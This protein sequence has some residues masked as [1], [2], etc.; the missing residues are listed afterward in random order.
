VEVKYSVAIKYLKGNR[1]QVALRHA[2]NAISNLKDAHLSS[3]FFKR[4]AYRKEDNHS[5]A[6][7]KKAQLFYGT[8]DH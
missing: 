2:A 7:T 6:T 5:K 3:F 8:Y 1:L 4:V